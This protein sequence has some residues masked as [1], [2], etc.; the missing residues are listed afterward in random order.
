M[1]FHLSYGTFT[2]FFLPGTQALRFYSRATVTLCVKS[3][4]P[5]VFQVTWVG[6]NCVSYPPVDCSIQRCV[7]ERGGETGRDAAV[8]VL[9]LVTIC[10]R[11]L[12]RPLVPVWEIRV[13]STDGTFR[14]RDTSLTCWYVVVWQGESFGPDCFVFTNMEEMQVNILKTQSDEKVQRELQRAAIMSKHWCNL[15]NERRDR[16]QKTR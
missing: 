2:W 8:V 6:C 15:L 10:Q 13:D 9:W 3:N 12:Q 11:S 14:G 16:K 1:C 5:R 7:D 4:T